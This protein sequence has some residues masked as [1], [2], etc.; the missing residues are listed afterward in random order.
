MVN[1]TNKTTV[2]FNEPVSEFIPSKEPIPRGANM[3]HSE[4]TALVAE[5]KQ[6][7]LG[8]NAIVVRRNNMMHEMRSPKNWGII[9][10]M[11]T[12]RQ[13]YSG[14][15]I[16]LLICWLDDGHVTQDWPEDILVVH[17][18]LEWQAMDARFKSQL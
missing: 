14:V 7:G 11:R 17:P 2:V 12:Y 9:R 6:K 13:G 15:Y 5:M 3:D 18:A 4:I 1:K 16:P 10:D 8:D